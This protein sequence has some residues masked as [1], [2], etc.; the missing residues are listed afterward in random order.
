MDNEKLLEGIQF[1]IFGENE[2]RVKAKTGKD[3]KLTVTY[4]AHGQSVRDAKK[5]IRNIVNV[6]RIPFTLNIIHG[7]HNGTAIKEMLREENFSGKVTFKKTFK[8]NKG[9]TIMKVKV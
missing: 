1:V 7:Y 6:A 9:K 8:D 3:G 4:D 5:D 2:W